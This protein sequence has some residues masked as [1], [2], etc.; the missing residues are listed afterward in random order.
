MNW[1]LLRGLTREQRHWGPF[2]EIFQKEISGSKVFCLD[3]PGIGTE[4]SR[5][6]PKSVEAI[7]DDLRTRWLVLRASTEGEWGLLSISLG[8]MCGMNWVSRFENDFSRFCVINSSAG[9]LDHPL[10]RMKPEA[11]IQVLKAGFVFRDPW[12]KE[13]SILA[14]TTN[15]PPETLH[16]LAHKWADFARE[17]PLDRQVAFGQ[18][19]AAVA[20]RAPSLIKIPTLVLASV[21]DRLTS[22]E[23][24]KHLA[25]RYHAPIR[26]HPTAGHDLPLEDPH[27]V[28]QEIAKWLDVQKSEAKAPSAS[29]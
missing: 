18:L 25:D 29:D 21:K 17:Y 22:P 16:E 8:G 20:F 15:L 23:C 3:Y 14:T 1:L 4:S 28:A 27:W 26:M 2:P 24:S 5:P 10:K 11:L 7:V 12:L 6:S 19:F 9:N 13:R